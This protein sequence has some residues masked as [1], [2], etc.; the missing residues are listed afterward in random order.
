MFEQHMFEQNM[1]EQNTIEQKDNLNLLEQKLEM[2]GMG[3]LAMP[4]SGAE[5]DR[6]QRVS[7]NAAAVQEDMP[8]HR[9]TSAR[10]VVRA[11]A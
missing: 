6:S 3:A 11:L 1:F 9:G 7:R 8:A 4:S 10:A 2:L 5:I